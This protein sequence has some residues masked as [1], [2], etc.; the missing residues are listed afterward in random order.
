VKVTASI[1]KAYDVRGIVGQTLDETVAEHLGRAFGTEARAAGETTVAVG[2]DGR[3]SGPALA[4]ALI[5]GLRSTGVDVIELGAVTT[6][7]TYYVAATRCRCGIQVTGTPQ[8][9]GLQRLQDGAGR[10]RDPR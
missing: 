7:M 5:R 2:R 4:A 3:L 9:E 1:F 10:P 8:P 6:P